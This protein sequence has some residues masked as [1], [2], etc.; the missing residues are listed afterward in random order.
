MKTRWRLF[1]NSAPVL[2]LPGL[3]FISGQAIAMPK[4]SAHGETE[5]LEMAR[6]K[7]QGT[8]SIEER[9]REIKESVREAQE[10]YEKVLSS[11]EAAIV[12]YEQ[13]SHY[14]NLKLLQGAGSEE[15]NQI[16]QQ[17]E[18]QTQEIQAIREECDRA[19]AD[20][21]SLIDVMSRVLLESMNRSSE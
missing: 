5:A 20:L 9:L 19:Y 4:Y 13:L 17:Q 7:S 11:Y 18:A 21:M 8:Q 14:F 6:I 16:A 15:L 3:A 1:T 2:V 10:N 12:K